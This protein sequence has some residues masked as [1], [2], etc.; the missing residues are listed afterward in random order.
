MIHLNRLGR[1]HEARELYFPAKLYDVLR[2]IRSHTVKDGEPQ[3]SYSHK[4]NSQLT[5]PAC[6][7][8]GRRSFFLRLLLLLRTGDRARNLHLESSESG[9]GLFRPSLPVRLGL[10]D[11]SGA[12][13]LRSAEDLR[14]LESVIRAGGRD[15]GGS[16]R[17]AR[18]TRVALRDAGLL[19]GNICHRG[20]TRL[21]H[22]CLPVALGHT[23][24]TR[25]P[26][27]AI[28]GAFH[29]HVSIRCTHGRR[30]GTGGGCCFEVHSTTEGIRLLQEIDR[31]VDTLLRRR[32]IRCRF[33]ALREGSRNRC[34]V[35]DE[36]SILSFLVR[37]TL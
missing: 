3:Y 25:A 1:N 30:R 10:A 5:S 35:L 29:A 31:L 33:F 12:H 26:G 7:R 21:L 32:I 14:A 13:R 34:A 18:S 19:V 6:P 24:T 8:E 36:R 28:A 17:A 22:L 20:R 4:R 2:P 11:P 16:A 15:R 23:D 37:R 9:A 27:L